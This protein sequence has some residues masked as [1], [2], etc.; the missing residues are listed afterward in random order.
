MVKKI[1]YL[2]IQ[3]DLVP[4]H[5]KGNPKFINYFP[6]KGKPVA[7]Y[8]NVDKLARK[9]YG[10]KTYM[11][12]FHQNGKY[13]VG[14]ITK[15]K[16][17]VTAAKCS[18]C[19]DIIYSC[20]RHDYVKCSCGSIAIDGGQDDYIKTVGEATVGTLNLFN[21][22]FKEFKVEQNKKSQRIGTGTSSG[23]NTTTKKRKQKVKAAKPTS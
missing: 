13:M 11:L 1:N 12:L 19:G 7:V 2:N 17:E 21:D 10:F 3:H 8:K 9:L 6:M 18:S 23:T 14:G 22:T 5:F 16:K 15:L 20:F 4:T